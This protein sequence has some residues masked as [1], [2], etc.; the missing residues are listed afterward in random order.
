MQITNLQNLPQAIVS[1]I[2]ND[3]YR[4]KGDI[5][6]TSLILPPRIFQLRRRHDHEI[7]EDASDRIWALLG[8]VCHKILERADNH[9]AFNEERIETKVKGW[10]LTGQSDLYVTHEPEIDP[11][12]G[13]PLTDLDGN[14]IYK[15]I[16][17]KIQ[18]YKFVKVSAAKFE[19][20]EWE[21]QLNILAY[22][23]RSQDFE[24]KKLEIVTIYRDWSKMEAMRSTNYPPP[25]QVHPVKMW[26]EWDASEFV[27]KRVSLH[28]IASK[29][30]DETL[31]FCLPDEQWRRD[32][33]WAVMKP[34]RT[35]AVKLLPTEKLAWEYIDTLKDRRQHYVMHRPA[36]A[37]RCE[38]FCNVKQFCNQ[39]ELENRKKEDWNG[40]QKSV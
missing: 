29:L 10:T 22:L 35:S 33:S 2:T 16:D 18:D 30:S 1:A 21:E 32:G 39:Y 9:G 17:P 38:H 11:K 34:K 20:R 26:K 40:V 6:A 36:Q 27:R 24:V 8:Q 12:T 37:I 13:D 3:P 7:T 28:Q 23:W 19:H 25:V 31:P 14:I 4:Q 5:T 15:Q